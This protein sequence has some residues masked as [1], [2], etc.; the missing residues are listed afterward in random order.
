MRKKQL[1]EKMRMQMKGVPDN[2]FFG[3]K[4]VTLYNNL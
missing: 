4:F 1:D 2:F 3:V